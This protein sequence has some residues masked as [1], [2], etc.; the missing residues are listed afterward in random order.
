MVLACAYCNKEFKKPSE[1]LISRCIA[2]NHERVDFVCEACNQ[3]F[4]LYE[5]ALSAPFNLFALGTDFKPR[6]ERRDYLNPKQEPILDIGEQSLSTSN[7][8]IEIDISGNLSVKSAF[9]LDFDRNILNIKTDKFQKKGLQELV[10]NLK[11]LSPDDEFILEASKII[12]KNKPR[13]KVHKK[14]QKD[15][16]IKRN[17]Q[18]EK[19]GEF[20]PRIIFEDG[21]LKGCIEKE[22][23]TQH[24]LTILNRLRFQEIN[25]DK[26]VEES[27]SKPSVDIKLEIE[28]KKANKAALKN[29]LNLLFKY[30][31][32]FRSM[33]FLKPLKNYLLNPEQQE[34][35]GFQVRDPLTPENCLK[36]ILENCKQKVNLDIDTKD[37]H[38]FCYNYDSDNKSFLLVIDLVG[39]CK[40]RFDVP[41]TELDIK[42]FNH[43]PWFAFCKPS[44]ENSIEF[45]SIAELIRIPSNEGYVN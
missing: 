37:T 17:T 14:N 7:D 20:Y 23:D 11:K 44:K 1:H 21:I 40:C 43:M 42:N 27:I 2:M 30:K 41:C 8:I 10:Y 16:Y 26:F 34:P 13:F 35:L 38:I 9:I 29:A 3:C 36:N 28:T 22:N 24:L 6:I 18:K 19:N 39:L 32:E 15:I 5:K 4:S 45:K 12:L 25:W 33:K 31:P